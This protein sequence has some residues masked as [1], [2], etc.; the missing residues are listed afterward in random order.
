MVSEEAN[1]PVVLEL[2]QGSPP[3]LPAPSLF[4]GCRAGTLGYAIGWFSILTQ[5]P[6]TDFFVIP[7]IPGTLQGAQSLGLFQ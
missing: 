1:L 3:D 6:L 5:F 7:D 4:Y 2:Q